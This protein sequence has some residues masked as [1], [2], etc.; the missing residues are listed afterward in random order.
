[1]KCCDAT[2][3]RISFEIEIELRAKN[4]LKEG[5]SDLLDAIEESLTKHMK[6]GLN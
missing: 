1:M 3:V 2:L 4:L 5:P 6:S